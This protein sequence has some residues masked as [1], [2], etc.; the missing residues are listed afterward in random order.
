MIVILF[1]ARHAVP[2]SYFKVKIKLKFRKT[3]DQSIF[4]AVIVLRFSQM[5]KCNL[6]SLAAVIR[7]V[8]Q[9]LEGV[10][11]DDPNNG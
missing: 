7:V 8:T 5:T 11:R 6:V 2:K 3:V 1:S 4:C 9:T 10:L